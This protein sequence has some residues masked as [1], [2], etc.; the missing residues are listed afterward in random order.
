VPLGAFQPVHLRV[1][2]AEIRARERSALQLEQRRKTKIALDT[3]KPRD[4][5]GFLA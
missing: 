4:L 1:D 2:P 3:R 5:R